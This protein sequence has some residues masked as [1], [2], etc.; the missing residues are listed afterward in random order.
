M[1]MQLRLQGRAIRCRSV[2]LGKAWETTR[3][4]T[5]F[6][7]PTSVRSRPRQAAAAGCDLAKDA[8]HQ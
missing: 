8:S 4:P 3:L 5:S 2:L 7:K 1:V 6:A